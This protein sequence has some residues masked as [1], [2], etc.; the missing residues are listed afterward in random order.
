MDVAAEINAIHREVHGRMVVSSRRYDASAE[1]VW[2]ACTD[3]DR[4][5]RW[6]LPVSGELRPGG[7]Y[8]LQG[9]AGGA[10]LRCDPPTLLRLT[11]IFGDGPGSVVQVRLRPEDTGARLELEHSGLADDRHWDQFGPGAVGVGWDLTLFGLALHLAGTIAGP[12]EWGTSP[13]ARDLMTQ[14]AKAWGAAHIVSG[15]DPAQAMAAAAR[16]TA[17][18]VP[19][20]P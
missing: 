13:E 2:Q 20:H 19:P 3:P 1:D 18:Y 12:D 11:W 17:F 8:Q 5:A 9:N 15:E 14:S 10:I 7:T 6:F 4:L 16:T